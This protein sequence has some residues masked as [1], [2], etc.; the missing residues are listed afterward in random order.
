MVSLHDMGI[1]HH[2]SDALDFFKGL[3]WS[4]PF[5]DDRNLILLTEPVSLGKAV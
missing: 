5:Y 2:L 1:W 4:K 3:F